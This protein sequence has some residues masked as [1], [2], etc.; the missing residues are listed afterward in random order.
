MVVYER[1]AEVSE[2]GAGIQVTPNFT[3]IL[4]RW[5]LSKGLHQVGV[6][7]G[8]GRQRRWEDGSILS[9]AALNH[10]GRMQTGY[11]APYYHIHRADLQA[12]LLQ[13][14]KESGVTCNTNAHVVD[15]I[16]RN[17]EDVVVLADG[18]HI[19]ADL[20]VAADGSRS[21]LAKHVLGHDVP[22]DSVGDSAYRGLIP[23]QQ[24]QDPVFEDLNLEYNTDIWIGP[25]S[26][27][28]T[29]YVRGGDLFNVVA[30]LPDEPGEESF[31]A[32]GDM[33]KLWKH[34]EGWDP[35]LKAMLSKIDHSYVWK[36]RDR[37]QLERW[38]H[39]QGN[40][41]LLGDAAHPMLPYVAQGASSA[42]EDAAVLAE[43]LEYLKPGMREIR[44][45][46][47]TYERLRK[48]RALRMKEVARS[49]RKH[50]HMPDGK[51]FD[52]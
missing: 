42:V 8:W 18:S 3:R 25:N 29:Y 36:L 52:R 41:V 23:R 38:V 51:C 17:G 12:L 45:V 30:I 33:K 24:M 35:R 13:Q 49:N 47:Q 2:I 1:E 16:H 50:N 19:R 34:F 28:V 11:G 21:R 9:Q 37:P 20:I 32:P 27:V 43:C 7:P 14:A 44:S 39:P 4:Q 48:P 31:K 40:L 46:L 6:N 15:Y 5:G 22:N 10:N 26:H